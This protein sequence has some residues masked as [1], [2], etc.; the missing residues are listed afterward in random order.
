MVT[1][2]RTRALVAAIGLV[3]A[4]LLVAD[5]QK[6]DETPQPVSDKVLDVESEETAVTD[7]APIEAAKSTMESNQANELKPLELKERIRAHANIDLPQD[8]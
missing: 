5:E 8:I 3:G 6:S 1:L 4:V 2:N 7:D